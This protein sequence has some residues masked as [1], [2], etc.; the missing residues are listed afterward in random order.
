MNWLRTRHAAADRA[1]AALTPQ[2]QALV[3]LMM[4][5]V[6]FT[7][8]GAILKHIANDLPIFVLLFL[9]MAMTVLPFI[10]WIVRNGRAGLRTP[11]IGA[12]ASRAFISTSGLCLNITAL[13]LLT[14]AEVTAISFT[15]VLWVLIIAFLFL[16]ERVG[17]RRGIATLV[18]F[19]GVL[20][21]VRPGGDFDPAMLVALAA[22][23]TGAM[24]MV[25]VKGLVGTE[26]PARIVIYYSLFGTAYAALPALITWQA[27]TL[28]QLG[29]IAASA[30]VAATGQF[31]FTR[32][33]VTGEASVLAGY[34]YL[35]L[36]L[37]TVVGLVLFNELPN[38]WTFAGAAVIIGSTW[39]ITWREAQLRAGGHDVRGP[40]PPAP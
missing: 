28:P 39:Y 5:I 25:A 17:V 27:P 38:V 14:L 21:M 34:E 35:K 31:C 40:N 11:R 3:W 18:G 22:A 8:M 24:A 29:W 9:R 15:K 37:A 23:L 19:L 36:P 32:A 7:A 4:S 6:A 16:G 1:L 12:H 26:P 20:I 10:P 13:S 2:T 33:L 30:A